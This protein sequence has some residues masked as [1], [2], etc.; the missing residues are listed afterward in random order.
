MTFTA[1]LHHLAFAAGL[2][3]LSAAVVRLM[4]AARVLDHPNA[5]S[6]HSQPTPKGGGVGIVV[7]FLVGTLALYRYADFARLAEPYFLAVIGA[8]FAIALV[9][10]LDDLLN[11][12]F[13][14]KLGA[15]VLAALV[16]V[17]SGLYLRDY[18]VAISRRLLC[19]LAGTTAHDLLDPVRH[20]RD[21]L[22]RR[23][24]RP[25]SWSYPGRLR[26]SGGHCRDARCAGSPTSPPC[27]WRPAWLDFCRST[28]PVPASS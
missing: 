28:S 12:P 10:L 11:W 27:C 22:H 13:T 26:F 4:I 21:E 15:Q 17:G 24:E 6:S 1:V 7:A 19:R 23:F 8:A 20:Q 14:V 25:G 9:G 3:L 16:A 5:R 2:A 18:R